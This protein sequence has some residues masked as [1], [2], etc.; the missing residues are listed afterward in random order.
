MAEVLLVFHTRPARTKARAVAIAEALSLLGDLSPT[1]PVG[2]PLG[3]KK[4][5][6]WITIPEG[7]V[8]EAMRRFPRLGYTDVVDRV[9]EV[10]DDDEGVVRWQKRFYKLKRLYAEDAEEARQHAPDRRVFV[11]ETE[12]G[13]VRAVRGY[14]GDGQPLAKRGLPVCDARL[15]VNLVYSPHARLFLDPFAGV[16]GIVLE[17]LASG[18]TVFSGD[19][20]PSLRYGLAEMGARHCVT[21]ARCLPYGAESVDAIASEPP[22][23]RQAE[24]AVIDSLAEMARVLKPDGKL[25][26]F[27]AEWQADGLREKGTALGLRALHDHPIDRKGTACT[28]LSWE[29]S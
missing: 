4:G 29:K 13:G 10:A 14:R 15:V 12:A 26:L 7:C 11:L 9:D 2:G 3:E 18:Y 21:D 28:V 22:Y 25:A 27:C 19:C 8:G 6:F 20:D 24:N 16:G 23:E 5:A 1:A 17:A